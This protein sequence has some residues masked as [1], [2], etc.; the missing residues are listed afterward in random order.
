VLLPLS[1]PGPI[2]G[3]HGGWREATGPFETIVLNFS[4]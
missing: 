1:L 3:W 2:P 4:A